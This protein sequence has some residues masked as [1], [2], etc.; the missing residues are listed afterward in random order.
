MIVLNASDRDL[1]GEAAGG[2]FEKFQR[3]W[4]MQL[5]A[6]HGL[7]SAALPGMVE[8]GWGRIVA[9][10]STYALGAPPPQMAPYV[11]AKSAL[12]AWIRCLASDFGPKGIRANLVVAGMTETA[13]LSSVPERQKKVAAAKNPSRRLGETEDVADAIAFLVGDESRYVNGHSLVVSGG[14]VML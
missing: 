12:A 14:G 8:A 10:G 7:V 1:Y 5:A 6:S 9:V 11:V 13:L 2:D 4:T 3:Q